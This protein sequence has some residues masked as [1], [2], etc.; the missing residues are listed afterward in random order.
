METHGV[1]EAGK[2]VAVASDTRA[3]PHST[4]GKAYVTLS[5]RFSFDFLIKTLKVK[6]FS[7]HFLCPL[8]FER[9]RERG[10]IVGTTTSFTYL[11]SSKMVARTPP[12]QK[13]MLAPLN[14]ILIRETL[15]K[16]DRCMARLQELQYTVTGGSKVVSGVNLSPRSTRGYLRTSLRCKQESLRLKNG[17]TRKS[18]V[19]K[20]PSPSKTGEW[21]KMS[22]PA[23][24]VGE[25]V[26][27]ILQAT[28]FAREIVS[29]VNKKP[30]AAATSE[31][32][33]TPMSQRPNRKSSM[34]LE[35]TELKA[36]RKK[37]KQT[38]PQREHSPSVQRARSRIN[39]KQ[40]QF[41]KT[42]SPCIP[43]NRGTSTTEAVTTPHKF[44]IKSPQPSASKAKVMVKKS[45]QAKNNKCI[46]P[47]RKTTTRSSPKRFHV[48]HP[49]TLYAS[50]PTRHA[51]LSRN[52]PKRSVS[53]AAKFRRSFSPSRLASILVSPL[54]S[55]KTVQKTDG[56]VVSGLK[57]RPAASMA[58]RGI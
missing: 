44:L 32:P 53:V 21:R 12:K 30:A 8:L 36:R 23:M 35:N 58:I 41:S 46:S 7:A 50:S 4:V 11:V 37:E 20:F 22:L 14:P 26:G 10:P 28:Q 51:N 6:S 5:S 38:K 24:L 42:G 15:I 19:G 9:E 3:S 17:A 34:H 29:A 2:Q 39:F 33:K 52:S 27:E 31:D 48:F 43:R 18:P 56:L 57:Q 1:I 13:K 40:Q 25:T 49:P 55:R 16:V 45:P 47:I 54:K